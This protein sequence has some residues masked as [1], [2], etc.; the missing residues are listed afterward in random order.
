MKSDGF[1]MNSHVF[2]FKDFIYLRERERENACASQLRGGAKGTGKGEGESG[3]P[4][5]RG[6]NARLDPNTLGS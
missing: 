5:S 2:I 4:L 6:P 1:Q 3:S